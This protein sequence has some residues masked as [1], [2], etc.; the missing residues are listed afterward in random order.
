MEKPTIRFFQGNRGLSNRR[1]RRLSM[2]SA[3]TK[4]EESTLDNQ[5][6]EG[7]PLTWVT[8]QRM[9]VVGSGCM[10]FLCD[11]TTFMNRW[12]DQA[13][14]ELIVGSLSGTEQPLL[15]SI[16]REHQNIMISLK[17]RS[18]H[19]HD[20]GL[21]MWYLNRGGRSDRRRDTRE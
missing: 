9:K 15:V 18:Q 20:G 19:L 21:T 12:S 6:P 5:V 13:G 14:Y 11:K 7:N 2:L 3:M 1:P 8:L 16:S 17:V 4:I 10:L